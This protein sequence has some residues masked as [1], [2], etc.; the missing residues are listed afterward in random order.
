MNESHYILTEFIYPLF[1]TTTNTHIKSAFKTN[2]RKGKAGQLI[3]MT[4][5]I[6]GV[7]MKSRQRN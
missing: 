5:M 7:S 4:L 1:I 2:L 6:Y 3:V